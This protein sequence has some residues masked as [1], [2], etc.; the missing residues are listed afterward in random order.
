[1]F[2]RT[3]GEQSVFRK[4]AADGHDF[5]TVMLNCYWWGRGGGVPR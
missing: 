3:H 1:M 2:R 4:G 5:H